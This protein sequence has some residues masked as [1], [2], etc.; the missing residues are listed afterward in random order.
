MIICVDTFMR[1]IAWWFS[2]KYTLKVVVYFMKV[3]LKKNVYILFYFYIINYYYCFLIQ[4]RFY[5]CTDC[6]CY[7]LKQLHC[8]Q[9]HLYQ[10]TVFGKITFFKTARLKSIL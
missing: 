2:I 7:L 8:I 10:Q 9:T 6:S 3:D 5:L 1:H 4:T